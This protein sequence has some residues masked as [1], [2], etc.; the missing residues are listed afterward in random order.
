M[1]SG[2]WP[3]G[4]GAGAGGWAPPYGPGAG[5]G[6]GGRKRRA[7][8]IVA[9]AA[10]AAVLFGAT[11]VVVAVSASD[12]DGP[13]EHARDPVAQAPAD[14]RPGAGEE[15]EA[16][17][18]GD[19]APAE[20]DP[21]VVEL[22]E[23][24]EQERGL[25]FD[26]PVAVEFLTAEE[27]SAEM[28]VAPEDVT[29]GE[30]EAA[31][32]DV[33]HL[34]A[35]GLLDEGVDLFSAGNELADIGSLAFYEPA[36]DRVVVRGTE[37]APDIQGTLVHELTH[38]LQYQHFD[39]DAVWEDMAASAD[40]LAA[41][42][43]LVE[44]D[45]MRI[46]SNWMLTLSDD[47]YDQYISANDAYVDE[48][49][50]GLAGVPTVL[51]ALATGPYSVGPGLVD[52]LA[53]DGNDAVDDAFD[54]PPESTEHLMDPSSYIVG[55]RPIDVTAPGLPAD[56]AEA[57]DPTRLGAYE[58]YL[59]LAARI[60]PMVA[61]DAVD[62]WGGDALVTYEQGGRSCAP[63]AV[64][65][66]EAVDDDQL[67]TALEAWVAAAPAATAANQAA[68]GGAAAAMTSCGD[69]N[70]PVVAPSTDPLDAASL[71]GARAYFMWEGVE[72]EG[73]AP[74]QAVAFA[75][76]VVRTVPFDVVIGTSPQ[77]APASIDAV[78]EAV[79]TC[80]PA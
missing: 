61:L 26:H 39:V 65:G 14:E 27:Y 67:R 51:D 56:A 80:V 71:L 66:D 17:D 68:E 18:E 46:E 10:A 75:G 13:D 35:F 2:G 16:G 3:A 22:V 20:W 60:D 12:D 6:G 50:E 37:L 24:V 29:E 38:A 40:E 43:G 47:E 44:G 1:S 21:R 41:N 23:Y 78:E 52:V 77:D 19:E 15:A 54:Q 70:A 42:S 28:R 33:A 64:D 5:A 31:A 76:C 45:A 9:G 55:D 53:G 7:W 72:F 25:E 63:R 69:P 59:V 32:D 36:T 49:G 34:V 8:G 58:L 4:A 62:G 74:D 79:T 73:L 48:A 57:A 11:A 30:R